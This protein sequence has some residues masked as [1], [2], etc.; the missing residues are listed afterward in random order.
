[1]CHSHVSDERGPPTSKA[2]KVEEHG[3]FEKAGVG[4]RYVVRT[5]L[6]VMATSHLEK[7]VTTFSVHL[8]KRVR[9]DTYD[10]STVLHIT[11]LVYDNPVQEPAVRKAS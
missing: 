2:G 4:V 8:D 10:K 3:T 9:K 5:A 11:S 7:R 6:S 1:M